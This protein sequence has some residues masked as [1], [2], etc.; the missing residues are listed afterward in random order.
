MLD[1]SRKDKRTITG[2][3]SWSVSAERWLRGGTARESGC[4][5]NGLAGSLTQKRDQ[6]YNAM[7]QLPDDTPFQRRVDD[8]CGAQF[9]FDLS[10]MALFG[11][12]VR[13]FMP[14]R[15]RHRVWGV[16][17]IKVEDG[18]ATR[19]GLKDEVLSCKIPIW[20]FPE[21]QSINNVASHGKQ[22]TLNGGMRGEEMN[23]LRSR[24]TLQVKSSL[25]PALLMKDHRCFETMCPR[26][27][28]SSQVRMVS[29]STNQTPV[30]GS[31]VPMTGRQR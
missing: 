21:G 24:V 29:S 20:F 10:S 3:E 25:Q 15:V 5:G 12:L 28:L 7:V 16:H 30:G 13:G 23:R 26:A 8:G 9:G 6:G 14:Y 27:R 31:F 18:L 17:V 1:R 2:T 4:A 19:L 22:Q 11:I